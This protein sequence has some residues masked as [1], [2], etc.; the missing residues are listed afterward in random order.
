MIIL[1]IIVS[2]LIAITV[3][4]LSSCYVCYNV[5]VDPSDSP[6]NTLFT[7]TGIML[8]NVLVPFTLGS[9]TMLWHLT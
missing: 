7:V 1:M 2:L 9:L 4:V 3:S 8:L 6:Q 5:A